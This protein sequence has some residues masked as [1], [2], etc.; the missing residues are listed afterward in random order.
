MDMTLEREADGGI[1]VKL[2]APA[3]E[4]N[5]RASAG[6][7]RK[8]DDVRSADWNQRRSIQIGESAN[9]SVF[10]SCRGDEV[11]LMIGHDDETWDVAV[12]FPIEVVDAIVRELDGV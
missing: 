3:W 11:T 5:V 1:L 2:R 4:I 10:W 12:G 8:L 9:A 7:L 6:D